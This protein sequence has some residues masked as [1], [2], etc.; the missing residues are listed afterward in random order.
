MLTCIL[1]KYVAVLQT[2]L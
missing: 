2:Q 1:R